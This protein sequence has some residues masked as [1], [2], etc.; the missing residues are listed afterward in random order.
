M[1]HDSALALLP[2]DAVGNVDWVAALRSGVIDPMRSLPGA[3]PRNDMSGFA[4]DFRIKGP[5]PMFDAVFS[6]ST[7][8]EWLACESCHPAIFP[9]RGAEITMAAI[10]KGEYC[11]ACHGTVAFPVATGCTRCHQSLNMPPSGN[12]AEDL[13][14][15]VFQRAGDSTD[16][17]VFGVNQFPPAQF[18]HA[19]HRLRYRC[20]AC[21]PDPFEARAGANAITMAEVS[22][23]RACG[24]CHDGGAAFSGLQGCNRCHVAAS[25][26]RDSIP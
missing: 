11:G 3:A 12:A 23:R 20:M 7:H 18:S 2:R 17:E 13:G 1:E 14:D 25:S 9:Y 6:H 26:P 19:V 21:H 22:A 10:N 24:V 16:Q 4:F 8:V 5:N 15:L